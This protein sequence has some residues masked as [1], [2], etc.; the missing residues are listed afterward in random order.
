MAAR[1]PG[2]RNAVLVAVCCSK[3]VFKASLGRLTSPK[4]LR[5]LCRL[6][7]VSSRPMKKF[8]G[9]HENSHSKNTGLNPGSVEGSAGASSPQDGFA[10][11]NSR[12]CAETKLEACSNLTTPL[13]SPRGTLRPH[14]PEHESPRCCQGKQRSRASFG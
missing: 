4:N 8:S 6:I 7:A 11:A 12:S 14:E 9:A 10:M 13:S 2:Q 1:S 5:R 3:A